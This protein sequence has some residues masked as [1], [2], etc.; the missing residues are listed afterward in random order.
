MEPIIKTFFCQDDIKAKQ[1]FQS[2]IKK[3]F[4]SYSQHQVEHILRSYSCNFEIN[5]YI[6]IVTTV[7]GKEAIT[8]P[9]KTY[10]IPPPFKPAS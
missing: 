7:V 3:N 5:F 9:N 10:N 1:A 8:K 2:G 6:P 4:A